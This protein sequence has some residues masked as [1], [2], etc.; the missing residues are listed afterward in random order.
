MRTTIV[1]VLSAAVI[2]GCG[3]AEHQVPPT[4]EVLQG[5]WTLL[6]L[7][8]E[9]PRR[10]G[11]HAHRMVSEDDGTFTFAFTISKHGGGV[12]EAGGHG[13]WALTNE[14]LHFTVL[15][16]GSRSV[17]TTVAMFP[18]SLHLLPDPVFRGSGDAPVNSAYMRRQGSS[19]Q[20]DRGVSQ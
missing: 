2:V 4:P 5:E 11:V 14:T 19:E 7:N 10:F 9:E 15:A 1:A 3:Q 13:T 17:D 6:L 8:A 12:T 20:S 16:E 18:Q